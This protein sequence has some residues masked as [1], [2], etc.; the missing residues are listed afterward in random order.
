MKMDFLRS[1]SFLAEHSL[2]L[3]SRAG[4]R[5]GPLPQ[6]A[7]NSLKILGRMKYSQPC[8]CVFLPRTS[9]DLL[10]TRNVCLEAPRHTMDKFL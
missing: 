1:G 9:W 4:I 6:K 2:S 5:K 7:D 10:G 8:H 3:T